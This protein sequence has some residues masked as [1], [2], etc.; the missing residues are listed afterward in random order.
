[1]GDGGRSTGKGTGVMNGGCCSHVVDGD[2]GVHEW[3]CCD[4][5]LAGAEG[6]RQEY[7][8]RLPRSDDDGVGCEGFSVSG[9]DLNHSQFM[10]GDL[11]EEL[12][13]HCSVDDSQHV[14]LSRLHR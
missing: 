12:F 3:R 6:C 11:K 14:C 7:V 9:V 10:A 2:G 4:Q 5:V 8:S 1:M 13:I